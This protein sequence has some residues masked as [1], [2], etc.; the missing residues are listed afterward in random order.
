MKTYL[1]NQEL[2]I[3]VAEQAKSENFGTYIKM[4]SCQCDCGESFAC[5]LID[6]ITLN[7]LEIFICCEACHNEN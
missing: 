5:Y 3:E 2:T 6:E 7:T 1:T 4:D